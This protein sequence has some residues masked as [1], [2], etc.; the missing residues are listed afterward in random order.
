MTI[1]LSLPFPQFICLE[2]NCH[3]F[4][5]FDQVQAAISQNFFTYFSKLRFRTLNIA[6]SLAQ[7]NASRQKEMDQINDSL[8]QE[9]ALMQQE[10]LRI[11]Q[12]EREEVVS[13][14][15][16]KSEDA[17]SESYVKIPPTPNDPVVMS[18]ASLVD[19]L[20][21][22]TLKIDIANLTKI[23]SNPTPQSL[24]L[25]LKQQGFQLPPTLFSS[26]SAQQLQSIIDNSKL[27][28][29]IKKKVPSLSDVLSKVGGGHSNN[30][31]NS[32]RTKR[33][34]VHWK[35]QLMAS[36]LLWKSLRPN[37]AP[38]M[39]TVQ[40]FLNLIHSDVPSLNRVALSSLSVI[41]RSYIPRLHYKDVLKDSSRYPMEHTFGFR[42]CFEG[43][44][45]IHDL[46]DSL[47]RYMLPRA[48]L[49]KECADMVHAFCTKNMDII[50]EAFVDNHPH[51]RSADPV[52]NRRSSDTQL[53]NLVAMR[54]LWP[55]DGYEMTLE[56]WEH[57]HHMLCNHLLRCK[58]PD[59]NAD[60]QVFCVVF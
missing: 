33:V 1:S 30:S 24:S 51:L 45:S 55:Y 32:Q 17:L 14:D 23:L 46:I 42:K 13:E 11:A 48:T 38:T 39:E 2:S 34:V 36:I 37:M 40:Y 28:Q 52:Q 47:P 21:L 26:L 16:A 29:F 49:T 7:G 8:R 4:S 18:L 10:L 5:C 54:Y 27:S 41:V 15:D 50:F 31:H 60:D 19:N 53:T 57:R 58:W 3:Y 12:R 56:W 35:Y 59:M 25:F 6:P 20:D 43:K 22:T 9:H 44:V